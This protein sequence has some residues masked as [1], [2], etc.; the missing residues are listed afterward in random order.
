MAGLS[1]TTW[2]KALGNIQKFS[3]TTAKTWILNVLPTY[4]DKLGHAF[5]IILHRFTNELLSTTFNHCRE[6]KEKVQKHFSVFLKNRYKIRNQTILQRE[7][8]KKGGRIKLNRVNQDWHSMEAKWKAKS[9]N[10]T[11]NAWTR[12]IY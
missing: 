5:M 9:N 2:C 10:F 3:L 11:E 7:S 1:D 12:K 8:K 6:W 4:Q